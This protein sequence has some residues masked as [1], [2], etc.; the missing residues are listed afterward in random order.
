MSVGC[1]STGSN[2]R[3]TL[4]FPSFHC[5]LHVHAI[6]SIH[7]CLSLLISV[8][9]IIFETPRQ[10]RYLL[11]LS[12]S[13]YVYIHSIFLS[14]LI[15]HEYTFTLKRFYF[16]FQ[17]VFQCVFAIVFCILTILSYILVD[18][19]C[20]APWIPLLKRGV[21]G[22]KNARHSIFT[23]DQNKYIFS[24]AR[25]IEQNPTFDYQ[26]KNRLISLMCG[27]NEQTA[28]EPHLNQTPVDESQLK[29]AGPLCMLLAKQPSRP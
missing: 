21:E 22:T 16:S 15:C 5:T 26:T 6:V 4:L 13:L 19:L 27:I 18:I 9:A 7:L 12:I 14:Y 1:V 2:R 29:A 20:V 17:K 11:Y 23:P 25:P 10:D 3:Q 24:S 8:F 28:P